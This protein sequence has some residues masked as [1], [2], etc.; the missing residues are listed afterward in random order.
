MTISTTESR[1]S[2][3]GNGVTTV[4]SFPYRFLANGDLVVVEVSSTGVE[5]VKTLTTHYTLTGAGDDAGGSVT[6][7]VAPASGVRLVIYRS[8]AIT[9]ETD[10]ISGDPFPAETH[11]RALDRL[12]M[13]A[14]EI[15]PAAARAIKVPV[16]DPT[17]LSTILPAA[18]DRL[19][20]FIAFDATTG[21]VELSTVTQTQVAS[22][23]AAA[24]AAGSTADAVTY[25]PEGTGA[26]SRTVQA[27]LRDHVS[28]LD[29]IPVALHADIAAGSSV[30]AVQ[31]YFA[32]CALAHQGKDIFVP[33][34]TYMFTQGFGLYSRQSLIG[35]AGTKIEA[36]TASWVGTTGVTGT[37]PFVWNIT[38]NTTTL[39]D[40]DIS[41][42][43]IEFDY[44]TVV[45][46]G[47]GAHAIRFRA[48]DRPRVINCRFT[49][50]ENA[51]AFLACRDTLVDEC[52]AYDVINCFYDHWDGAISG[53]VRNCIGRNTVDMAQGIQFTGTGSALEDR[54]SYLFLAEG[55]R[56]FGVRGS[57]GEASAIIFNANDA[58]S[59]V[60]RCISSNNYIEDSD[61]GIVFQGT[62]G[63][64]LSI[65][66][67]LKSVDACPIFITDDGSGAPTYSRVVN[68]HLIDCDHDVASI[69][70]IAL[71]AGTG[72]EV[73]GVKVTNSGAAAY[74]YIARIAS[75]CVSCRVEIE[76]AASGSLGR[77][78][79]AS[80][81]SH[82]RDMGV[83]AYYPKAVP[84]IASAT[85]I[86]PT[87][88]VTKVSGTTTIQTITVPAGL[89]PGEK[90][91]LVPTGLWATNTS[92]NIA[93]VVTAV[94]SKALD[95]YWDPDAGVWFPSY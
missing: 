81:T 40:K 49:G 30:T 1:I 3:N 43:N 51:T 89:Q 74:E 31:S 39:T 8:T 64:N 44:D 52:E 76:N 86:A 26:V 62:V 47:G 65:N 15:S 9:Q 88:R 60:S 70:M 55:N 19:D 28:V 21:A 82:V 25:L 16:G 84:T 45:V 78:T 12:T 80:T 35:E 13:I 29:F 59:T 53:T 83:R 90:I 61:L 32:A 2:Y 58:G 71:T 7:L 10:Y 14:Q 23:V 18:V 48:V 69:A 79:N 66:D 46:I 95:L 36:L 94:V 91:T 37:A 87:E 72:N 22:A 11:E 68:P 4:F 27:R 63:Y 24:Y 34:G 33:A 77:V 93:R 5:T 42:E 41:V 54:N 50:G 57:T 67:T 75:A 73:T 38:N 20:R 56:L 6:M 17:S 92:G 85:T